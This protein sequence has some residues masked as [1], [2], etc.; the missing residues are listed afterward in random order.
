MRRSDSQRTPSAASYILLP[1]FWKGELTEGAILLFLRHNRTSIVSMSCVHVPREILG[2]GNGF[3]L[4]NTI[5]SSRLPKERNKQKFK[6]MYKTHF[7]G[8]IHTRYLCTLATLTNLNT[9]LISSHEELWVTQRGK[10]DNFW[11][12]LSWIKLQWNTLLVFPEEHHIV[13]TSYYK[14]TW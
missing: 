11:Y 13:S 5:E 14:W 1:R 7:V 10:N 4:I 8:P 6:L 3:N 2:L 12:S 9:E